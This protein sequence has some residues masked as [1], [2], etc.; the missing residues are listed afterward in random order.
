MA[1]FLMSFCVITL[2]VLGMALGVLCGRRAL[3]GSCG[4]LNRIEGLEAACTS[5]IYPCENG[6]QFQDAAHTEAT[7]SS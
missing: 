6:Q 1:L 5:C 2:A 4:G 3:K 7:V